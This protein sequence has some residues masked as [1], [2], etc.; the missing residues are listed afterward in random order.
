M[1]SEEEV[2]ILGLNA[3]EVDAGETAKIECVV[4]N[5]GKV[6][7]LLPTNQCSSGCH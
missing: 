2:E 5:H 7:Y 6:K 1:V 4:T 3:T